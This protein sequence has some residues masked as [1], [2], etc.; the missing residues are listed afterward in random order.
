MKNLL[1][2]IL[3]VILGT[4]YTFAQDAEKEVKKADKLVG[5]YLLDTKTGKDK[6]IE[7]KS[8]IDVS[9]KDPAV[10]DL[11][12]T[13]LVKGKVYNEL[14]AMDNTDLILS[15]KHKLVYEDAGIISYE[16][17]NSALQKAV[18]S[19]EKKDVLAIMQELSQYLNNFGSTLYASGGQNPAKFLMAA[20]NFEAVI[21]INQ[22]LKDGGQKQILESN[23]D[24]NR[25]KYIVAVCAK[26]GKEDAMA[27]KYFE[28][29]ESVNYN[30]STN[31]GAVVYESLYNHYALSDESKADAF[32]TKGRSKFPNE[33][34]L[35]F[36]EINSFIKKGKLNELIDKLKLAMEKESKNLSIKS[37]LANVYD[38]LSQKEFEVGNLS[39]GDEYQAESF[40]YYDMVLAEDPNNA[41]ALY[42]KGALFYNRAAQVS[43]EVNKLANDYSAAGTAKY[44]SK[45]A[46]MES[47]FDKA[48]PFLEKADSLDPNDINTLIALKEIY[49]KK[50]MFDKSN[51]AKSRLEK[52]KSK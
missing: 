30:D 2:L 4:S 15:S 21:K 37:T 29:L 34:N 23:D 3:F 7:A 47:Y 25:Q 38:N 8:I 14:A 52:L 48:L 43:K 11:Y 31:A 40:K 49:A 22:A 45:K 44:N 20:K 10:A 5:L 16:A 42:S 50:G 35:L 17:L 32:L 13:Y 36:A 18:K 33:T 12:K 27:I 1:F 28:E 46:E 39:K 26:A 41:G 9:S 6:L 19:F 24:I 51:A